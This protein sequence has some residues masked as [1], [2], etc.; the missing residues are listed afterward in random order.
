MVHE[1]MLKYIYGCYMEIAEFPS[2][3]VDDGLLRSIYE[4]STACLYHSCQLFEML[5]SFHWQI[6]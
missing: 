5:A 3:T 1:Y 4:T 6:E 2:I